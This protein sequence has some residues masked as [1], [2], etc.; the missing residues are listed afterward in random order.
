MGGE[1]RQVLVSCQNLL[2][3]RG[4]DIHVSFPW[5]IHAAVTILLIYGNGC[6]MN[7]KLLQQAPLST[8]NINNHLLSAEISAT[9]DIS[10]PFY[11]GY[12]PGRNKRNIPSSNMCVCL[13]KTR[14]NTD[15]NNKLI[16]M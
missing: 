2:A 16:E 10:S 8:V 4:D 3:G 5:G 9:G 6:M 13:L 15:L 1:K 11:I 7:T 14:H 12:P